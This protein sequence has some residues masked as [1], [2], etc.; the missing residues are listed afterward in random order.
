MFIGIW[1][2]SHSP[3][4]LLII[5]RSLFKSLSDELLSNTLEKIEVSSTKILQKEIIPFGNLF[6]EIRK[7][8][9]PETET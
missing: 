7:R 5:N 1:I 6:M 9:V 3:L 8:N 4:Y 2:E